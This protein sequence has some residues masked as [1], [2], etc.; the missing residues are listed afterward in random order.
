M[1]LN[2]DFKE[3]I[4]LLNSKKV[5]YLVVGGYAVGFH[6][7]PRYT[8]DIDFWIATSA[9]NS[10]RILQALYEFGFGSMDFAEEDF[11][12]DDMVFQL[13]YPPYRI[14]LLTSVS[15]LTFDACYDKRVVADLDGLQIP[16][17]DLT[18]LKKN[19]AESGR[20]KDLGDLDN[21]P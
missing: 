10:K 17:L 4:E 7:Y 5:E 6:G 14:D 13:G 9:E 12:N 8:G 18:S 20:P 16:F 19:K 1:D 21:L 15:G 2:Q 3:F 11:Q